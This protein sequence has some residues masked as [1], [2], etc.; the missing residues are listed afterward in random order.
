[1]RLTLIFLSVS[2]LSLMLATIADFKGDTFKVIL[3]YLAGAVFWLFLILGYVTF[4]VL[5]KHRKVYEKTKE[6]AE[7]S[8]HRRDVGSRS[9]KRPLPGILRF[10]SNRYA[11]VADLAMGISIILLFVLR[12]NQIATIIIVSILVLSVHL[13]G[14]LNGINFKYTTEINAARIKK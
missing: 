1:M 13:H 7:R 6:K 8:E 12:N 14:I 5:S 10:F 3:A 11:A 4:F 2:S 9:S